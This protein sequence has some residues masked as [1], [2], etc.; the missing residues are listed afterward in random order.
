MTMMMTLVFASLFLTSTYGLVARTIPKVSRFTLR[1]TSI[2]AKNDFNAMLSHVTVI[3]P[4]WFPFDY[5]FV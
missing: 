2:S 3:S 4:F 1:M 5:Y